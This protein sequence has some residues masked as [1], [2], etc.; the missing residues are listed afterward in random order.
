MH[1]WFKISL[2]IYS[3][4]RL[5][6]IPSEYAKIWYIFLFSPLLLTRALLY[7][8]YVSHRYRCF[9]LQYTFPECRL[10]PSQKF[11]TCKELH[12]ESCIQSVKIV[13]F[14]NLIRILRMYIKIYAIHGL[15]MGIML[16]G[17]QLFAADHRRSINWRRIIQREMQNIGQSTLFLFG[18]TLLQRILL[19]TA[20]HYNVKFD[21]QK[22]YA[23]SIVG[24]IP[25]VFERAQRSQ[26]I[27]NLAASHLVVGQLKHGQLL[28]SYLPYLFFLNVLSRDSIQI[29]PFITSAITAWATFD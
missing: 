28:E 3:I 9:L 18:Q 4:R 11:T 14:T 6:R 19:C 8:R 26:Q 22:I 27:N 17:G 12:S 13:C 1:N 25:I 23:L 20:T 16:K 10:R 15:L 7:P 5:N 21:D 2:L 24:S 29:I